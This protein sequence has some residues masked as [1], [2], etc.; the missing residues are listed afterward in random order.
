[1]VNRSDLGDMARVRE[2][3]EKYGA[4]VIAEIPYSESIIR[5]YVDG[6]PIV[7]TDYPEAGLFKEIASKVV[8]FLGGGE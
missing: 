5:S 7:L 2:I 1:V 3:A 6:K 4:E 8:E